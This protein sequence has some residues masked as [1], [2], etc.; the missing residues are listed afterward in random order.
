MGVY[1]QTDFSIECKN[2]KVAKQVV[3][4]LKNK[5]KE[6]DENGNTYGQKIKLRGKMVYGFEESPRVQN[7]E[8]R[9]KEIWNTIKD[10]VGVVEIYAPFLVEEEGFSETN[11]IE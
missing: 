3:K 7:L 1:A 4:M 9:C 6:I 11:E 10:I 5:N 2:N 8:Y